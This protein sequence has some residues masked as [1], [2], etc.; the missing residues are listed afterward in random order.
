MALPVANAAVIVT[1]IACDMAERGLARNPPAALADDDSHFTFIIKT[2]R[3][4]R[5]DHR[6]AAA[7]LAV[8]KAGEDHRMR[9][10]RVAAFGQ[11]RGVVDADAEYL[12]GVRHGR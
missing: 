9:R 7:D 6:L 10:G 11:V 3:L 5:A 2:L 4:Q 8:G 1:G 12:V